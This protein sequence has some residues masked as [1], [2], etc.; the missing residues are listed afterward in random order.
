MRRN[1]NED[2]DL[3]FLTTQ[4]EKN[5]F[6]KFNDEAEKILNQIEKCKVWTDIL[7]VMQSFTKF[8]KNNKNFP[9]VPAKQTFMRRMAQALDPQIPSGVHMQ[10]LELF[11]M[12]FE[13]IGEDRIVEDLWCFTP[14][15]FPLI[16]SGA[17]D[18][19]TKI[20]DIIKKYLLKVIMKM[21]DIQ[22]AFIISVIVG[23]EE[24]S[25]GIKDKTIELIDEVKKN[26][27]KYFWELCWDILRSNSIS[28]KPLL[29][30]MLL[31]LDCPIK[32]E[33]LANR[34]LMLYSILNTFTDEKSLVLR[35]MLDIL[36]TRIKLNSGIFN[37]E[38]FTSIVERMLILL[39]KKDSGLTR[40]VHFYLLGLNAKDQDIEK[41]QIISF[42]NN[43]S[44]K[45]IE[46]SLNELYNYASKE[47]IENIISIYEELLGKQIIAEQV[48][49]NVICSVLSLLQKALEINK[50]NDIDIII[51]FLK[52]VDIDVLFE[53][54]IS[55]MNN[56]AK[57]YAIKRTLAFLTTYQGNEE[58][59]KKMDTFG[60]N[61]LLLCWKK[62]IRL[63]ESEVQINQL[64]ECFELIEFCLKDEF[65]ENEEKDIQLIKITIE[66]NKVFEIFMKKYIEV[67]TTMPEKKLNM[68]IKFCDIIKTL[69]TKFTPFKIYQIQNINEEYN[70]ENEKEEEEI[71][72][73]GI[74]ML[75]KKEL[76]NNGWIDELKK[77]ISEHPHPIL[78][79]KAAKC[80]YD[81]WKKEEK[82]VLQLDDETFIYELYQ[83]LWKTLDEDNYSILTDVVLFFH[84][85]G[86]S[87]EQ[88]T[89]DFI[90][91][92]LKDGNEDDL[93]KYM[94]FWKNSSLLIYDIET[95]V[96]NKGLILFLQYYIHQHHD[97][98]FLDFL[99]VSMNVQRLDRILP[100][101]I[102][103]LLTQQ[104]DRNKQ[105][106]GFEINDTLLFSLLNII[107]TMFASSN[108]K[109]I[110][111]LK[112]LQIPMFLNE[113]YKKIEYS[114]DK[115]SE[116]SNI[117]ELIFC[118][119]MLYMK[120]N[121][122][123]INTSD[124]TQLFHYQS[125]A[126]DILINIFT[127]YQEN[128]I[129]KEISISTQYTI[130]LS[131]AESITHA[132]KLQLHLLSLV[133]LLV[134]LSDI[135]QPEQSITRFSLFLQTI[136]S[137][138]CQE[139]H[140]YRS[141]FLRMIEESIDFIP[142]TEYKTS[143]VLLIQAISN[144][145]SQNTLP[146][147]IC[148]NTLSEEINPVL[149]ILKKLYEHSL[150]LFPYKS[151]FEDNSNQQT[152]QVSAG[153]QIGNAVL[154]IP[155][156][157][158]SVFSDVKGNKE[159]R[160]NEPHFLTSTLRRT[161]QSIFELVSVTENPN[162]SFVLQSNCVSVLEMLFISFPLDFI[163]E[164]LLMF[165]SFPDKHSFI[166]RSFKQEFI[167]KML[168]SLLVISEAG[169]YED[170]APQKIFDFVQFII[171]KVITPTELYRTQMYIQS[172]INHHMVNDEMVFVIIHTI[173]LFLDVINQ[174]DIKNQNKLGNGWEEIINSILNKYMAIVQRW[175]EGGQPIKLRNRQKSLSS[176]TST[177]SSL[178]VTIASSYDS[179]DS[180]KN[181]T[182]DNP[183][184]IINN[185]L[186]ISSDL[187]NI[188]I[189]DI[190]PII[191]MA[192][193]EN[194]IGNI[195]DLGK[196]F[197]HNLT[198]PCSDMG[199][200]V[201]SLN[202]LNEL[203]KRN[204]LNNKWNKIIFNVFNNDEFFNKSSNLLTLWKAPIYSVFS[205]NNAKL[206]FDFISSINKGILG[207]G[208]LVNKENESILR[209]KI[210]KRIAFVIYCGEK[211]VFDNFMDQNQ[212]LIEN[213]LDRLIDSIKQYPSEI[214]YSC[215]FL[216]L[217]V[218][219][220][221]C[222]FNKLKKKMPTILNELITIFNLPF[223]KG[224]MI[225]L[226][227][228]QLFDML[229]LIPDCSI[230]L[231]SWIFLPLFIPDESFDNSKYQ[232]LIPTLIL[233]SD[234]TEPCVN[235]PNISYEG[236]TQSRELIIKEKKLIDMQQ[237]QLLRTKLNY[238]SQDLFYMTSRSDE[239]D[240]NS[241]IRVLLDN[242]SE[243]Q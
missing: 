214:L 73:E 53:Y 111:T 58:Q 70:E 168:W 43:Y 211:E 74:Q 25:S 88:L 141:H 5:K 192:F 235:K 169:L 125:L 195:I 57:D 177:S 2:I 60:I 77:I 234:D 161:I 6:Q 100:P 178:G 12:L 222:S 155:M 149:D 198:Q 78:R 133:K 10:V 128:E 94:L 15:L 114:F 121:K 106:Y 204:Q 61:I 137:G 213:I 38:Q 210:F 228:L 231:H 50:R 18:I 130:L 243:Q 24:N 174:L 215:G 87:H 196:Q 189:D 46:K 120:G 176:N 1:I 150:K 209:A 240:I 45:I 216:L 63:I 59:M 109:F 44:Y 138:I 225:I 85:F 29:T 67:D 35:D 221:K 226:S 83:V 219:L 127:S 42:F 112:L 202:I 164:Y 185:S 31:K 218:M 27:E 117:L 107:D 80:Y 167:V 124:K 200:N 89:Y 236:L 129:I 102:S 201:S 92:K 183:L 81:I 181:I 135:T 41:E 188:V 98:F 173:K 191:T 170:V 39:E 239:I 16:R 17:T 207:Q 136:I 71:G 54:I 51:E 13:R 90:T 115:M 223:D 237:Y 28:R 4:K 199:I 126:T 241:T 159:K 165:N 101:I 154:F 172:L 153:Q 151:Q 91:E 229:Q 203:A 194:S 105:L 84:T 156:L 131:F 113:K 72:I 217:R 227:G 108:P 49:K 40:R 11:V 9:V 208:L 123:L 14:G 55:L 48:F 186:Y 157:V 99:Q 30:Y 36:C 3:S 23:M 230:D 110:E 103:I 233:P 82:D 205:S 140:M 197:E 179:K 22:K 52:N 171:T 64:T 206:L 152:Q 8:I 146:R 20:L 220:L 79:I 32:E 76:N 96:F 62:M 134:R 187:L 116:P 119:I 180:S 182:E 158:V 166:F 145:I 69:H 7:Q 148:L 224:S 144:V 47:G 19:R 118:V 65:E 163:G 132:P 26:N 232:P 104:D 242:F 162:N 93:L 175:K 190:I 139:K 34:E 184:S 66:A 147:S 193:D 142:T 160:N 97:P 143:V 21:K 86:T 95:S 33:Q 37:E 75:L 68:F 56:E 212:S 238:Y 122:K